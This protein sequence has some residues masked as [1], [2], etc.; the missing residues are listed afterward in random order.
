MLPAAL[1]RRVLPVSPY[2]QQRPECAPCIP[3]SGHFIALV[4]ALAIARVMGL[5][6]ASL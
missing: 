1:P 3:H 6:Q 4:I 5:A 2:R